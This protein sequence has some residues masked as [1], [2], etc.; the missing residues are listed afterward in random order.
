M[1]T[2]KYYLEFI[3]RLKELDIIEGED[4]TTTNN[5]K[6][7]TFEALGDTATHCIMG[8][9]YHFHNRK[10]IVN[11]NYMFIMKNI[12]QVEFNDGTV[13]TN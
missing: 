6:S 10:W 4:Y 1:K 9:I 13:E 3:D 8:M 7:I 11:F 5:N 12:Q 2:N